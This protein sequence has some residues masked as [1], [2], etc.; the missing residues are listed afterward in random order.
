MGLFVKLPLINN[1]RESVG[2]LYKAYKKKPQHIPRVG[3]FFPLTVV[4]SDNKVTRHKSKVIKISYG[5]HDLEAVNIELEPVN[6]EI[7]IELENLPQNKAH[8]GW[9]F[10]VGFRYLEEE[11]IS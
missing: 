10:D 5:G 4:I 11:E 2:Y 8:S 1:D 6:V 7:R 3:E 9:K